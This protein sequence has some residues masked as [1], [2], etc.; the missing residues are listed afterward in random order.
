MLCPFYMKILKNILIILLV[1]FVGIQFVPTERNRSE[2]VPKSDFMVAEEV[3]AS[4]ENIIRLL[5][6]I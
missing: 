1:A 4:V 3:P 2:T 5:L 6:K